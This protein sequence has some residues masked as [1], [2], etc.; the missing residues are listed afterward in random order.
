MNTTNPLQSR[1]GF[2]PCEYSLFLKLKFLHKWY[3]QTVYDFHRWHRWWRKEE[4]NRKGQEPAYCQV[5][6]QDQPWYKPVRHRDVAGFQVYPKTV[7]DHGI[8]S[9]YQTARKPQSDPVAPLDDETVRRI[10]EL[11]SQVQAYGRA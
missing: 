9:L 5:F 1:W 4:Q 8:V 2:Y 10:E 6:V 11:Y 3:W 7:L